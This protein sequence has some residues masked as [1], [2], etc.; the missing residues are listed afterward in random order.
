MKKTFRTLVMIV[1]CGLLALIGFAL[2]L[3]WYYRGSFPV[4]T[5]INGVYCT[6]MTLQD[7]NEKLREQPCDMELVIR[8]FAGGESRETVLSGEEIGLDADYSAALENYL[9]QSAGLAWLGRLKTPV[10]AQ[11]KPTYRFDEEKLRQ[12]FDEL[13]F[14]QEEKQTTVHNRLA[15]SAEEGYVFQ[16]GNPVRLDLDKAYDYIGVCL[17]DGRVYIDL[18]VGQCYTEFEEDDADKK[19]KQLAGELDVFRQ[20]HTFCYDMG[21]IM[22]DMGPVLQG[23]LTRDEDGYP[24]SDGENRFAVDEAAVQSWVDDLAE[25][26]DTVG[27]TLEFQ[28]TRGDIVSVPYVNYGTE[29]NRKAE[30]DYL[31]GVLSGE[32]EPEARHIPAYLQEGFARGV[33]DIGGT[34]IEVDMSEQHLYYYMEGELVFE[35]DVVTGKTAGKRRGTPEGV[36]FVYA[37]Q[38]NRT[39]RGANYASFVRYWMPVVDNVGLHDADWRKEFG[40]EIYKKN[41]SHGC[42]NLPL[43]VT[44]ELYDMVEIGTPVVMFY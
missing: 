16:E 1:L 21:D 5:W 43:G 13:D 28:S 6:G 27:K 41:G 38:R 37:K 15:Y 3:G 44:K 40:G 25:K 31:M 8:S 4:N 12:R 30:V 18:E 22:I 24:V 10:E 9:S 36:N 35:T 33:N 23:F 17:R 32:T 39:L 29:L 7:V 42:V 11:I 34:F 2:A 19:R 20:E 26:Y 14:V